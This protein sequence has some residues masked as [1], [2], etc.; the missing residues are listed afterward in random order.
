MTVL[1][2]KLWY[3]TFDLKHQQEKKRFVSDALPQQHI[4]AQDIHD[5]I[6]LNV[7]QH[8]SVGHIQHNYEYMMYTLCKWK[9]KQQTKMVTKT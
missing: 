7:F 2:L 1:L 9:T 4:K 6:P 8:L 3:Y 5:V